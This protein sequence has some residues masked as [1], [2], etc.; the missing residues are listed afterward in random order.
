MSTMTA[1]QAREAEATIEN[2]KRLMRDDIETTTKMLAV[3]ALDGEPYLL[4]RE[5]EGS[6]RVYGIW[7]QLYSREKVNG[8]SDTRV[9]PAHQCG[10]IRY[11]AEAADAL[12]AKL[13]A[14]AEQGTT[15]SKMHWRAL[16]QSRLDSA[17]KMLAM[18]DELHKA[19]A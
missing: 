14:T 16:A 6:I 5:S 15:H 18:L 7:P 19:S 12:V 1:E 13:N 10:T 3:S 8:W 2:M 9:I 17:K 4:C 11:T